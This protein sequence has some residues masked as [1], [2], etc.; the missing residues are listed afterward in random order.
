ML[1]TNTGKVYRYLHSFHFHLVYDVNAH[2]TDPDAPAH[3]INRSD[4]SALT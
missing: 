4:L 3:W 2:I 1:G